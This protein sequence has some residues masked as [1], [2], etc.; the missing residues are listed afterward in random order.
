PHAG[1]WANIQCVDIPEAQGA[2]CHADE[3]CTEGTV[4]ACDALMGVFMGEDTTCATS[5]CTQ[6]DIGACCDVEDWDCTPMT[7]AD[8]AAAGN[9]FDGLGTSCSGAC[10]EY[11][12]E[13]DPATLNYNPGQP[14]ADDLILAGT[15]R[16]VTYFE[17][18]VF[19]G[20]GGTFDVS[21]VFYDASPCAGGTEI[22]GSFV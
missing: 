22:P 8:C 10:P 5:D 2:C 21:T 17:I 11:R 15:A 20:G 7:A 9:S 3:S 13:I 6:L 12:N 14:M 18:A 1:F 16:D 19:G 4:S